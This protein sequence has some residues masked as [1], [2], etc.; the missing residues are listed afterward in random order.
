[1]SETKITLCGL[2]RIQDIDAVNLLRPDLVGFVFAPKSKR[3]VTRQTAAELKERLLPGIPVAGVFVNEELDVVAGLLQEGIIDIAQLHGNESPEYIRELRE[4]TGKPVIRAIQ[5][6]QRSDLR[7]AEE[8]PAD[9]ILLDAGMGDGKLL[10]R[11]LLK[12]FGRP[13]FLAGGLDCENVREA[14]RELDPYGVD[15][16]SGIETDG[17]KDP[18]KMQAFIDAVRKG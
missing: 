16:S 5:V 2:K 8:S 17:V 14:I 7:E 10:D 15:A 18:E 13:Y 3:A 11:E 4:K 1:M 9:Y 12:G 6:R